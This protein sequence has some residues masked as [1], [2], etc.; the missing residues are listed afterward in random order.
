MLKAIKKYLQLNF[1][2][3]LSRQVFSISFFS[4]L[5][6][7][8]LSFFI[9]L[10]LQILPLD[11]VKYANVMLYYLNYH[12][13]PVVVLTWLASPLLPGKQVNR[14]RKVIFTF[15][16]FT[17]ILSCYISIVFLSLVGV[18]PEYI[19][20]PV[21][22]LSAVLIRLSFNQLKGRIPKKSILFLTL[23]LLVSFLLPH[24]AV[25]SCHRSITLH[26]LSVNDSSE[27][28]MQVSD[29]IRA[30]TTFRFPLFDLFR[31]REDVWKFLLV[32]VGA[33]GEIATATSSLLDNVDFESRKVIFPGEDHAF[34]E[35]RID[36]NWMVLDPGYYYS[37]ILTRE[38]RAERRIAE[39]GAI[40][41][42][43]GFV[44]SSFVELTS[45]YVPTDTIIIQVTLDG[46]PLANA[47]IYLTHQFMNRNLRLPSSVSEFYSDCNGTI[48]VHLGGLM[49][50]DKAKQ[51]DSFYG[52]H[53]NDKDTGQKITSTGSGKTHFIE[54]DLSE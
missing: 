44:D 53:V 7:L 33:C 26:A 13:I 5:I 47:R 46:E 48:I 27:R 4:F 12:A 54:I 1:P 14:K 17:L 25:F 20:F 36:G 40:S 16:F 9:I 10:R 37:E 29:T 23:I 50:S 39:F 35:V 3:A 8:I 31:S 49:Y 30:T 52:I 24:I 6:S 42:V 51:Y 19:S 2:D 11:W 34:V 45:Q 15:L 21:L 28:A 22:V 38:Q 41:Y 43:V 18:V 32:G